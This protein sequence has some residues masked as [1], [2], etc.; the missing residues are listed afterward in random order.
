MRERKRRVE[1]Y[2]FFDHKGIAAHLEYMAAKGWMIEKLTNFGWVYRRI[3]PKKLHFAVS[4]YPK[5]SEFDPEP[6]EEQ[7]V[8]HDFCRHTGWKLAC[9][10]GQMQIFYNEGENP[11]PIETEPQLELEAIRAS[12]KKSF[13]PSYM[14]LLA[15]ALLNGI[16]LVFNLR[17]DP[18]GLLSSPSRLFSGLAPEEAGCC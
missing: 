9:A 14:L 10:S 16:M 7:Q 5:A 6:S 8:F 3:T 4:Y 2:S 1:A 15:I 13:L 11:T 17:E 18:I 12:A